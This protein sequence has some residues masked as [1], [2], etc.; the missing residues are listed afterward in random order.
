VQTNSVTGSNW[1]DV[2]NAAM[3]NEIVVPLVLANSSA[4]YR[5]VYP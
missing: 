5:L 4:F 1:L 2:V 3:T